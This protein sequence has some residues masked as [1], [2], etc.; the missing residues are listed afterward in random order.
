M[1]TPRHAFTL[2]ELL[3]TI[4][5]VAVLASVIIATVGKVRA[6]ARKSE[7]LA[8]LR[9]VAVAVLLHANDHKGDA[10]AMFLGSAHGN[11]G[12]WSRQ[13]VDRGYISAPPH[14]FTCALDE[15]GQ[16]ITADAATAGS[17]Y[18]RKS[19]GRSYAYAVPSMQPVSG[20]GNRH[21]PRRITAAA[22]PARSLMLVEFH[23][24]YD[25]RN[26]NGYIAGRDIAGPTKE[27]SHG[28]TRAYAFLDG[29]VAALRNEEAYR[30]A[31][32]L[33]Q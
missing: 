12:P 14:V 31:L 4:A 29:H 24:G 26:I 3:A 2:V 32:W 18:D 1:K 10:P 20:D 25:Y 21:L 6:T 16:K 13:L 15:R 27:P 23:A 7:C 33:A 11:L 8:N 19:V 22:T 17:D 9:Q 28:T 30:A 5:V